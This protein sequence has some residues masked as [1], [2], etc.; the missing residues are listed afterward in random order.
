M[1]LASLHLS[2]W[3]HREAI[4]TLVSVLLTGVIASSLPTTWIYPSA[5]VAGLTAGAAARYLTS[6]GNS[7]LRGPIAARIAFGAILLTCVG[8]GG[9]AGALLFGK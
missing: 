1:H 8:A 5:I 6:C 7:L 4:D 9:M 3:P 2:S